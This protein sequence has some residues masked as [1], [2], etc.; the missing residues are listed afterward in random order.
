M[1]VDIGTGDGRAV[2][3]RAR[4]EPRSLVLGVD[5]AAAA[6]TEAS[7]RA[8]RRGPANVLFLAAGVESL[9]CTVLAGTVD[10]ATVNFPWGSLLRGVLGL[11][12]AALAGVAALVAPGG[13]VEVFASVVAS[14]QV[15]GSPR[16]TRPA[17]P[18]SAGAWAAVGLDLVALRPASAAEIAASGSSWAR[19]LRATRD[20]RP[21]WRLELCR[22]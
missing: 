22:P 6:M 1:V 20:A 8:A 2:V 4:A 10:L 14:D 19:R 7:R 11:D 9:A 21:V 12:V 13:R 15:E 18:R 5:A 17:N 3:A 16:S